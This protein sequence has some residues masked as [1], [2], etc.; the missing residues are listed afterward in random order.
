MPNRLHLPHLVSVKTIA[1]VSHWLTDKI[2]ALQSEGA[3]DL[4]IK[5]LRELDHHILWDMGINR[6]ALFDRTPKIE[7]FHFE[8]DEADSDVSKH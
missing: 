7:K 1:N 4:Q 3:V 5:H 2:Y 6:G 8:S